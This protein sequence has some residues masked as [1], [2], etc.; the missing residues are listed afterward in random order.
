MI[1]IGA[2]VSFRSAPAAVRCADHRSVEHG[3]GSD[4]RLDPMF[5]RRI[6]RDMKKEEDPGVTERMVRLRKAMGYDFHGGQKRFADEFLGVGEDRWGNVERGYP[7]SKQLAKIIVRKIHG[8]DIRWLFDGDPAG[9]SVSM[10]QRLGVLPGVT[11][12]KNRGL[13]LRRQPVVLSQRHQLTGLGAPRM[14]AA[15][16]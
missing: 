8:V 5:F 4:F 11:P 12:R 6:V 10:A 3:L 14:A 15:Q 9:L 7:L 2:A 1:S 13:V 16:E